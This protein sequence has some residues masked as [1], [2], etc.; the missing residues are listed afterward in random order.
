MIKIFLGFAIIFMLIYFAY[1][2]IVNMDDEEL[3]RFVK[4]APT[5]A[6]CVLAAM[7]AATFI[8]VSF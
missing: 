1:K 4:K 7:L 6:I 5:I 2:Y 8:V 3:E